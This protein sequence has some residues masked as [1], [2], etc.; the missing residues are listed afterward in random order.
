M[1]YVYNAP[2]Q[3]KSFDGREKSL[4]RQATADLLPR[5]VYDRVKSPYPSTQDPAY[6]MA[7]RNQ[8]RELLG[9]PSHQVFDLVSRDRLAR[10]TAD[11]PQVSR[12]SRRG[13]EMALNLAAWIDLCSPHLTP[14]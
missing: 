5:S 13:M 8:A 14:S 10:A 11:T 4:L 6:A 9:T 1:E 2:W 3:L 7:L 12:A